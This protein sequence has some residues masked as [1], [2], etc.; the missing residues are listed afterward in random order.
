MESKPIALPEGYSPSQVHAIT[1]V[2]PPTLARWERE[3]R[4]FL[5]VARTTGGHKRYAPDAISRI[6]QLKSMILE[7]GLSLEGA[8]RQLEDA[9]L[10][11]ETPPDEVKNAVK[12][13]A[14]EWAAGRTKL[15]DVLAD[16]MTDHLLRQMAAVNKPPPA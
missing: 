14:A 7:H 8:K 13:V 16:K 1:G 3:F 11:E 4:E 12:T 6:E 5:Q 10:N 2:A 9:Q 15:L